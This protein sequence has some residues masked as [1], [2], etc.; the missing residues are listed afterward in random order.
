MAVM[1]GCRLIRAAGLVMQ[2]LSHAVAVVPR[3]RAGW[4][5]PSD[6][7]CGNRRRRDRQRN[8]TCQDGAKLAHDH[9][10]AATLWA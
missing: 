1:S 2:L 5:R 9:P 6:Q 7:R 3:G 10:V 8:E 4:P